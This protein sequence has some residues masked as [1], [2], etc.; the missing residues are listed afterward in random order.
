MILRHLSIIHAITHLLLT[1]SALLAGESIPKAIIPSLTADFTERDKIP[2]SPV[3]FSEWYLESKQGTWGPKA[4]I[5]PKVTPPNGCDPI[6]WQRERIIKVAERYIGL[7]YQHHH[8]PGWAPPSTWVSKLNGPE[9]AG[10][11]CSN[12]TSWVYNY[13]LGIKFSSDITEQSESKTAPGR[14]LQ[15]D[16]AFAAGD[17][18]FILKGDR[19]LVSH[20]VIYINEN[21]IIDAHD[22]S[23]QIRPFRGWYKTHL[24]HAR[25]VIE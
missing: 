3:P 9:S 14:R 23:I 19:S 5:Y 1:S 11:D 16:E 25:R 12:F 10:L 20:V 8:I 4:T 22:K 21:Q 2:Q 15:K 18:L 24:S 7:S 13:G 6:A 17:L